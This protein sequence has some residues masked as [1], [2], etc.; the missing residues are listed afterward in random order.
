MTT[1]T[2]HKML[3]AYHQP[4]N[5]YQKSYQFQCLH[6]LE[7]QPGRCLWRDNFSPG[8]FTA[9]AWVTNPSHTKVFLIHHSKINKWIQFGGHADGNPDL[10]EVALRELAEESG[11]TLQHVNHA[12]AEI[13][14][15]DVHYYPPRTKNGVE[16]PA[17]LHY[18]IRFLIEIDDTIPIPGSAENQTMQWFTIDEAIKAVEPENSVQRMLAKTREISRQRAAA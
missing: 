11:Y 18:D 12:P 8:H 9:S 1:T 7:S 4:D 13:F 17:H 3:E 10:Q 16:E 5:S 6:M 14:D 15:I 2:L